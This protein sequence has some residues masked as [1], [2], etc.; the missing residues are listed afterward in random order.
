MVWSDAIL[1]MSIW[2]N[3]LE[4]AT[5]EGNGPDIARDETD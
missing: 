2:L 5:E 1:W 4:D 3:Y